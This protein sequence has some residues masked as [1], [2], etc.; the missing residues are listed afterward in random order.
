MTMS[1]NILRNLL[2]A[3]MLFAASGCL[4][5][6]S[7]TVNES[8][9]RVSQGTLRQ[10]ELGET[11]DDWLVSALGEPTSRSSAGPASASAGGVGV[12]IWGYSHERSKK[13]RGTLFLLFAGSSNK[14]DRETT[15]FELTDGVVTRYWT[16]S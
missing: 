13:S 5:T 8:G 12:E 14:V 2:I 4:L 10:V 3:A 16:E 1:R 7:N 6:T 15:Y 9:V 11:T